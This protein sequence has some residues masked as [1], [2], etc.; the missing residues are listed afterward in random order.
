[1]SVPSPSDKP[2]PTDAAP[3]AIGPI[4]PIAGV[5][6]WTAPDRFGA[7]RDFYRDTLGLPE[8]SV[9]DDF[10]SFRWPG[11]AD[12][13]LNVSIHRD[14]SGPSADP[15]RVMVNFDV[16]DLDAAHRGLVAAGV[17]IIRPP[18]REAWGGRVCT[19]LDP[20]GNMLQLVEQ[21]PAA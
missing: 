5:I 14:L 16:A 11:A 12:Q 7:M 13:R 17:P 19:F 9:R 6:L 1:M 21:P 15:L 2:T 10:I 4:G 3:V 8:R 18:E 20:D